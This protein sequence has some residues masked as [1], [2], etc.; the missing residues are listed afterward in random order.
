MPMNRQMKQS[1]SVAETTPL[2]LLG[3]VG[4]N[5]NA[6]GTN[7]AFFFYS[8][9]ESA[10]IIPS[11]TAADQLRDA[12]LCVRPDHR[13]GRRRFECACFSGWAEACS[14]STV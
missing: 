4:L 9:S 2:I 13:A 12:R 10:A 7:L 11:Q 5:V 3:L 6:R 8:G 1:W 14:A